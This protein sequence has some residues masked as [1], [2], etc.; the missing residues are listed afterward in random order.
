MDVIKPCCWGTAVYVVG[1][2]S[3]MKRLWAESGKRLDDYSDACGDFVCIP[4]ENSP[5]YVG[6][7]PMKLFLKTCEF[8]ESD[9]DT[10]ISFNWREDHTELCRYRLRHSGVALGKKDGITVM[11]HQVWGGGRFAV[12]SL[13]EFAST[14]RETT[15]RTLR[16]Y[17]YQPQN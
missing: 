5:G 13:E 15:R 9:K 7:E 14:L 16:H 6:E 17:F 3:R 2:N 1:G 8:T 10:V 4:D 11:F 12:C